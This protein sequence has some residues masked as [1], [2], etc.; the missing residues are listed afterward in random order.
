MRDLARLG[1]PSLSVF[2]TRTHIDGNALPIRPER[3]RRAQPDVTIR[4]RGVESF[5][6]GR[7]AWVEEILGGNKMRRGRIVAGVGFQEATNGIVSG[8]KS[9]IGAQSCPML[10]TIVKVAFVEGS[11]TIKSNFGVL[12]EPRGQGTERDCITRRRKR[13]RIGERGVAGV[14][15]CLKQR[16]SGRGGYIGD[17]TFDRNVFTDNGDTGARREWFRN[18]VSIVAEKPQARLPSGMMRPGHC[19]SGRRASSRVKACGR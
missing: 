10:G 9:V 4:V 2:T 13:G 7:W 19:A 12:L 18:R 14:G 17:G 8:K 16:G 5:D 3:L 6:K 15:G 1:F 11:S